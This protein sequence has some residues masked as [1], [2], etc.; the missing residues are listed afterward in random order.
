MTSCPKT[1]LK[2]P[3]LT[4]LASLVGMVE[5]VGIVGGSRGCVGRGLSVFAS[6]EALVSIYTCDSRRCGA[7]IAV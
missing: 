6:F 1:S 5:M 7:L 3:S 4:I 2:R